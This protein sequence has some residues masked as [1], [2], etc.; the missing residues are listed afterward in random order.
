MKQI[1]SFIIILSA[2]CLWAQNGQ[3]T[4][5]IHEKSGTPAAYVTITVKESSDKPIAAGISD[6]KGIFRLENIPTGNYMI[7]YSLTGFQTISNPVQ[8]AL[9]EKVN[10]G[11]IILEPDTKLLQEVAITGQRS[12]VSLKL[13]KKVF[14]VGKDILS[15]SGAVTDLLTIVPSVSV[16]P[17]GEISLRGNSNVLV[18]IDGR[19]TGLTQGNALEQ[20]PADQVERV[21]VI[22]NPSSRFDAAG[23]AGII[24][25]ILKKN[26][27]GGFS[28]QLRLVG[29]IPNE[30]RISPSLN[31]KSDRLNLFATYGIR[32]SDYVGL[33]TMKQSTG[34]SGT[35]VNLD[36]RQDENR[37]D[38][39]KLLYF[40]A[41]FKINDHNTV[42]A[43][44]MRNSTH[45][46]DK[47]ELNYLYSNKNSAI[48]SSLSRTGESWEKRS[49]N[50]LE[51]NYTKSFNKAGKKLTVD[52]Q[53]D[54]WDSDKDWNLS[55]SK[56]FPMAGTLPMIRTSSM[57]KSKDFMIKTDMVQP[58]DS[59]STLEFGLK[60]EDRRVNS[61]F[62]A[63]QQNAAGW[64]IIDQIDNHLL[65]KELIG[66]TYVQF[67]GKTGALSY[68]AGLRGEIT[69]IGI[70][71]REGSYTNNKE[72]NKLFPTLNIS[73]RF[74]ERTT[75]QGSYSKRINRPRLGMIY[76]FN[77]LTDLSSRYIGNPDLNPSYANVFELAFLKN[78]K[79]LTFNPSFYYQRNI[80]VMEDYTFR[81]DDGLFITMPVNINKETRHGF[82]LSL[83][84]NPVKW[85]QVNTELN[86]FHYAER[87]SY[88]NQSFD[89][90]GNTWTARISTQ[91]KLKNK[92]AFQTLY[93]FRGANATTQTRTDALHSIDFGLS[94]T[95][96]KDKATLM[97]DVS[98]L[99]GLRKSNSRTIG[100]DYEISQTSI[101]NAARYRLT[102]VYR[103]NQKDNQS[104]RQ[105]KSGNR[106]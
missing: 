84:Y 66:S 83:L 65:Y 64:E 96:L 3:V 86:L 104:V 46:H 12:S 98:N 78:W 44:F 26:K 43:A 15:Q 8:L 6:A 42:T 53:Y 31:Y 94:K 17:N 37:H 40:G 79:N 14:E 13:D 56:V 73:Y 76:P 27:K 95:F 10:V 60:I 69:R 82:E 90:S 7:S 61:D 48:D 4:G 47:T 67:S 2:P 24:N 20:V 100:S 59:T 57:G 80:G 11:T 52:M 89:Y 5:I 28:G 54:F 106:D 87:G 9:T 97:F 101:P 99:G 62:I 74:N 88:Q 21:E 29:G 105:A 77:E 38:D 92:L 75:L 81:N 91:I 25:I 34:L 85:L 36:Q 23:S 1:I 50:Q 93:N 70:E 102:L 41:D 35:P 16:S 33:Y 68:Q 32:L 63:E 51:F 55:T 72:Y 45:D 22:T 103:F 39:A 49:Y 58:L 30:T 18:L 19:R 71:D